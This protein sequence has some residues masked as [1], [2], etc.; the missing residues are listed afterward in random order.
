MSPSKRFKSYH[1]NRKM[2]TTKAKKVNWSYFHQI[3]IKHRKKK[4]KG[5]SEL[6]TSIMN[7]NS[8]SKRTAQ[9]TLHLKPLS[10]KPS[11]QL[12]KEI[13]DILN[14]PGLLFQCNVMKQQSIY[15]AEVVSTE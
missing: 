7:C 9:F 1:P 3:I 14:H 10:K 15:T 5:S 11:T 12:M 13:T 8:V 2:E 6:I 4:Q